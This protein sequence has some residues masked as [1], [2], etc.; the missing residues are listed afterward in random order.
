MSNE[1][2]KCPRCDGTGRIEKV[3]EPP[4]FPPIAEGAR[5]QHYS[6]TDVFLGQ[7]KDADL[8]AHLWEYVPEGKFKNHASG[9]YGS[10]FIFR[11]SPNTKIDDERIPDEGY[12][13]D[14]KKYS[15]EQDP[16][17]HTAY[18]YA[19]EK[20]LILEPKEGSNRYECLF[21]GDVK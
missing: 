18:K 13:S 15:F 21:K 8:Y 19:K 12:M 5:Y 20:G 17:T 1:T 9:Y 6:F 3:I 14:I 10:S 11:T 4:R 7:Y 2:I 16:Y